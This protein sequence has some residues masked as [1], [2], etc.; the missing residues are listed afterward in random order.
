VWCSGE[1]MTVEM[2]MRERKRE[3]V[4]SS[5]MCS[6]SRR[7]HGHESRS[8]EH[9]GARGGSGDG[10]ATWRGEERASARWEAAAQGLGRHVVRGK[11]ARGRRLRSTWPVRAVGSDASRNRGEGLEVEDEGGFVIFQKYRDSTVKPR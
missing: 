4:G 11:V 6:G 5:R 9:G 8:G 3:C 2:Q 1:E 7:R 10:G